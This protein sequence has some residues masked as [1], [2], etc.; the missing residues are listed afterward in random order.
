MLLCR[1][2]F[3]SYVVKLFNISELLQKS[4]KAAC[5]RFQIHLH[6]SF[7]YSSCYNEISCSTKIVQ[8]SNF[9]TILPVLSVNADVLQLIVSIFQLLNL[10]VAVIMDNF[11]Y[12]TRDESILGPHHMDEFVR[13]WSEYDPSA[14]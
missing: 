14:G 2:Y 10:F 1:V 12:L 6:N 7:L 13:V 11:D 4:T 3:V 5:R 9:E 8:G